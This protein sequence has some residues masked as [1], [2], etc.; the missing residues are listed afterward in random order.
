MADPARPPN[1]HAI[2]SARLAASTRAALASLLALSQPLTVRQA[3]PHLQRVLSAP[4]SGPWRALLPSRPQLGDVPQLQRQ[5]RIQ[6]AADVTQAQLDVLQRRLAA[7][8]GVLGRRDASVPV[9]SP[10]AAFLVQADRDGRAIAVYCQ[11]RESWQAQF[12]VQVVCLLQQPGASVRRCACGTLFAASGRQ[13][14]CS[15]ACSARRRS[16]ARYRRQHD[17]IRARRRAQY[18][19]RTRRR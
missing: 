1:R 8:L 19:A 14:A 3:R 4:L 5:R 17:R 11:P 2:Q 15:A 9:P 12:W 7:V 16:A 13:A 18:R 10:L 6:V